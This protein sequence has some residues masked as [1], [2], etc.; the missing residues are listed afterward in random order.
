VSRHAGAREWLA[1]E[2]ARRGW[3]IDRWVAHLD[4][5][6]VSPGDRVIGVLPVHLAALVSR[7]GAEYW[8]LAVD[9]AESRRGAE[10][11]ARE[12]EALGARLERYVVT[13]HGT[14]SRGT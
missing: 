11:S 10:L 14:M 2:A 12:L 13:P 9:P 5:A 3:I 4:P 8:H 1:E 7:R 6:E